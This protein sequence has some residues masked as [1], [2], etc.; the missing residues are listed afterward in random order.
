MITH[1]GDTI[2]RLTEMVIN[3]AWSIDEWRGQL[4]NAKAIAHELEQEAELEGRQ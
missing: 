1:N 2:A 4:A 3:E